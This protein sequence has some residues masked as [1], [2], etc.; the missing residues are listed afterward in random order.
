MRDGLSIDSPC[1]YVVDH[2]GDWEI[3]WSER[4]HCSDLLVFDGAVR[5]RECGTVYGVVYG[6][7]RPPRRRLRSQ[8]G[9]HGV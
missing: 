8:R 5:C 7:N 3:D 1:G 6:F 9:G 4:C 2:S